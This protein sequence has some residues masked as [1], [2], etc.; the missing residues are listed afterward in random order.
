[1]CPKS[2][3]AIWQQMGFILVD[4]NH[5]KDRVGNILEIAPFKNTWSL[6]PQRGTAEQ[7]RKSNMHN[8]NI[9]RRR[10]NRYSKSNATT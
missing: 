9:K 2:Q 5:M 6:R 4:P 8:A 1:M 10:P 3:I 7:V